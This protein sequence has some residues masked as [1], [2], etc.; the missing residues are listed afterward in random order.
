ME[1]INVYH[2]S[3]LTDGPM[4]VLQKWG[5][6]TYPISYW[7]KIKQFGSIWDAGFQLMNTNSLSNMIIS[8]TS[9]E[10]HSLVHMLTKDADKIY[11]IVYSIE[12]V[13]CGINLNNIFLNSIIENPNNHIIYKSLYKPKNISNN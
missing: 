13:D 1:L 11:R 9:Y 12:K 3:I 6:D 7:K 4:K 10:T 2:N 8:I 5:Q